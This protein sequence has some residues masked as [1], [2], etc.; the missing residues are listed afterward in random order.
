MYQRSAQWPQHEHL[1]LNCVIPQPIDF[2]APYLALIK[3]LALVD[4]H[5][6]D[7]YEI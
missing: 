4:I 3:Y 5:T 7:Y 6:G 2:A 1:K